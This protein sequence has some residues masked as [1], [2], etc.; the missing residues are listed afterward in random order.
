MA[1]EQLIK[2]AFSKA[3]NKYIY[4]EL[5][6]GKLAHTELKTGVGKGDEVD[7]VMH[8]MVKTFAYDGGDLPEA[9]QVVSASTKIKIDKGMAVHF[10]LKKIEEDVIKNAKSDEAQVEL[11]RNYTDDAIKQFAA[12]VDKAYGALYTRAGHYVDD[13]GSAIDLTPKLAKEIFAYMQSKFQLG[14]NK[15]H[16]NW[17]TGSM[18]A[19]VPPEY[20]FYLGQLDEFYQGVESG[21]KKIEKGFIGKLYGWDILVSNDLTRNTDGAI[22]P[23][24]GVRGKTLAGGVSKDLNMQHYT[25]EKNFNTNYKGYALYGVGAPRADFLGAVKINAPL[26]LLK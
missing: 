16:T 18:I 14:D 21:H 7:V 5:V 15:G 17:V 24:F 4:N 19:I 3:F 6:V 8:G 11:I 20:Q 9:E 26:E 1:I 22:Y 10:G 13:N 25:P 12:M 23:L 2:G